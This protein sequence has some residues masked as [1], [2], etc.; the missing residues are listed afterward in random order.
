MLSFRRLAYVLLVVF[1]SC[2]VFM[3]YNINEQKNKV[4]KIESV[5]VCEEPLVQGQELKHDKNIQYYVIG[6]NTEDSYGKIFSNV[7]ALMENLKISYIKESFV[8]NKSLQNLNSV[9]IFCDDTIS[10]YVDLVKLVEFIEAGGKVV[11]SAGI[12]EGYED[13]Y[14]LPVLGIVEKGLKGHYF[15]FSFKESYFPIQ[16][17]YMK[18]DGFSSSTWLSLRG[19]AFVYIETKD[20]GAPI[21]YKHPY[22]KGEVLVI[23]GLFLEDNRYIGFLTAGL[24]VFLDA[25]IYPILGVETVYLDNFPIVTYANDAKC[26]EVYGRTTESF[27]RDVIW[28][29]FL[30]I[31]VK[32]NL[33][34][35]SSVLGVSSDEDSFP[36][37]SESLFNTMGKS[38][39]QYGGEMIYAV[40]CTDDTEIY[41]NEK[42]VTSFTRTFLNYEISSMA[43]LSNSSIDEAKRFIGEDISAVRG[44][45]NAQI[46]KDRI[47]FGDEYFVFPELTNGLDLQNRNM[48][49]ISSGLSSYGAV[50]HTFDINELLVM[51]ENKS[52]WDKSKKELGEFSEKIFE[53]TSYLKKV[54]LKETKNIVKSYENL[55]YEY[56]KNGDK[57]TLQV[58]NYIV[59][60][61]FF[62][63]TEK[64]IESVTGADIEKIENNYY[65]LRVKDSVVTLTMSEGE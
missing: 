34:Y 54:T 29:E 9:L 41:L 36:V 23:N 56:K 43:M 61:P 14:L 22:E 31:A 8:T 65:I 1:F 63:R 5:D 30:G 33:K 26:L 13:S 27:V 18:Y 6:S 16:E 47:F 24:S 4:V 44:S 15:E 11:F 49:A 42:F 35:T 46:E 39:L 60:Q 28:P 20:N 48:L 17:D 57:L 52:G 64:E 45:I 37:I 50:S 55:D 7:C 38:A 12:A 59:G 10:E 3:I 2:C 51:D 21:V 53:K 19:E 25:F 32:N 58:N 62:Y 40:D